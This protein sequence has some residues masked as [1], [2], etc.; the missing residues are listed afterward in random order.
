MHL[1]F[2]SWP[3]DR[4]PTALELITATR[5]FSRHIKT[6]LDNSL[7][8]FGLSYAQYEL[9]EMLA[10]HPRIHGAEL[11]RHLRC[12]PQNVDGLERQ[13]L[14]AGLIEL[15]SREWVR[16]AQLTDLGRKRLLLVRS[17]AASAIRQIERKVEP[18]VIRAYFNTLIEIDWALRR[19]APFPPIGWRPT[20]DPQRRPPLTGGRI[21]TSSPSAT[22]VLRDA[23]S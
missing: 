23:R 21:A 5:R 13:L 10:A 3:G 9:M 6:L 7:D 17:G 22:T 15:T 16:G 4:I 12:T 14:R 11:A 8:G 20:E 1:L 2:D 19:P 18:R